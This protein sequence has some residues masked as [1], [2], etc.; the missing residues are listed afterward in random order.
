MHTEFQSGFLKVLTDL[1]DRSL[2]GMIITKWM[3]R[4]TGCEEGSC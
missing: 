4:G 2:C 3:L 1:E